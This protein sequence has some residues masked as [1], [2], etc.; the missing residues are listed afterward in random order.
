MSRRP[1]RLSLRER[2]FGPSYRVL[3]WPIPDAWAREWERR[4][5]LH[6]LG[7][8]VLRFEDIAV[9]T[10]ISVGLVLVMLGAVTL[11]GQL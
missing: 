8:P 9:A 1:Q 2:W 11:W 5:Y 10:L 3:P 7:A 6:S 4:N